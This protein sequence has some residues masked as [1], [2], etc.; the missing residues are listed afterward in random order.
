MTQADQILQAFLA[1]S[2][3]PAR[4]IVFEGAVLQALDRRIFWRDISNLMAG[5]SSVL[6]LI[7]LLQPYWKPMVAEFS[8]LATPGLSIL[9]LGALL[10]GQGFRPERAAGL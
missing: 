9:V 4:D 8:R 5:C 3:V 2:R 6:G 7:W 10:V 1:E